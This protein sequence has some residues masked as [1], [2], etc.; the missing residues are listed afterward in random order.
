VLKKIDVYSSA[1]AQQA[2][3]QGKKGGLGKALAHG[4]W[5]FF[6]TYV[7]R[8]G[9]L[10]GQYGFALAISNAATSYYKYLKLWQLQSDK[11]KH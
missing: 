11:D 9:F 4:F 6:R 1:A 8:R 7:L 2:F 3:N 10:D 5:A